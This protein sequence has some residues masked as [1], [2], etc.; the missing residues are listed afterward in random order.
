MVRV[1]RRREGARDGEEDDLLAL[2]G[3]C[4]EFLRNTAREL[5]AE[6]DGRLDGMRKEGE[7]GRT[8]S[9][10]SGPQGT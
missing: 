2:P 10:S 5:D 6:G 7:E 8:A 1:A 3:G 9:S 4:G